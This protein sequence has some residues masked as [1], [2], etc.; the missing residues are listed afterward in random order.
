MQRFRRQDPNESMGLKRGA[1]ACALKFP[2]HIDVFGKR[3]EGPIVDLLNSRLA[4][5][6]DD[7]GN[8]EQALQKELRS[9]DD[10][11]HR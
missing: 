4:E 10:A 11:D 9:L 6:S 3:I 7:T 2:R 5:C 8:G 1:P